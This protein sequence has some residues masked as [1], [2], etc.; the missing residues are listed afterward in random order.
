[1]N[2]HQRLRY[3]HRRLSTPRRTALV[4]HL[5]HVVGLNRVGLLYGGARL[6]SSG[7]VDSDGATRA[8]PT[9][10]S[11]VLGS[12][13]AWGIDARVV[14]LSLWHAAGGQTAV[15]A[16]Q[17]CLSNA[18][19][20]VRQRERGRD[21]NRKPLLLSPLTFTHENM[22]MCQNECDTFKKWPR[23]YLL[24]SKDGIPG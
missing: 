8:S 1:M 3:P 5:C 9:A 14:Q 10:N 12:L 6:R 13:S 15:G 2:I 20:L 16:K 22:N 11:S 21:E 19:R 23:K 18:C 4:P 7:L 24:L 17:M